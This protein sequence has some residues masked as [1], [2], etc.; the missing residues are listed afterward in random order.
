MNLNSIEIQKIIPHRYPFLLVD[1]IIDMEVGKRAVGIKNVTIN[2]PF[3]QGHFP[4][5]PIMPG[6]LIVEAMAQVAAVIC[7][8][9]EENEGKLGVFTGI[10]NCKFR[11]Q[12]VPGDALHIEIE[13]T[14]FRRGIGKAEGKAY[15]DGQLACSASLTFALIDKA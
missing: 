4:D 6:V 9:S 13:M 1:K 7:M 5:Q 2:E 15:V 3:F 14:A 8:G 10:D 12:V 11:K